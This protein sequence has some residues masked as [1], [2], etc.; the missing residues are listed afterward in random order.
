MFLEQIGADAHIRELFALYAAQGLELGRISFAAHE[1][2]RIYLEDGEYEAVPAGRLR[3][4]AILPAVGDWVAARQV[5]PKLALIEAVLP[6][7]TKFS[8]RIAGRTVAEQVIAANVDLAVIV[9]GLDGDFNVR[10]MER[11]LV[12]ARESGGDA[13]IVLNKSDLC[14]AVAERLEQVAVVA[15]RVPH[16]AMSARESVRELR[17]VIRGRTV[18]FLG[19]SGVG[20]STIVNVLIGEQS[21]AVLPVRES[22]SRGRH[23]TTSRML[24]PLPGGGAIIDNP[25]MRELQLWATEDSLDAVF[26]DVAA[27]ASQCRFRDCTHTNEPDCAI[28]SALF[29]GEIESARWRSYCKLQAELRHDLVQQDALAKAAVKAK[30]KAIHKAMRSHPKYR[31]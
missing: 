10:R 21:Q 22:D 20:K 17:S 3:Y 24:I 6:R 27:L 11:Y 2:Y 31:R 1:Q 12:L 13:L 8:R 26:D 5:D 28:Q 25:G 15:Q 9:C 7:R 4:E 30:W 29:R 16:L 14:D 23:T 19:S 18:A